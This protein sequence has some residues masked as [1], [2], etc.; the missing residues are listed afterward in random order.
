[1]SESITT[2]L[3]RAIRLIALEEPRA[4]KEL[5][6]RLEGMFVSFEFEDAIC[7]EAREGELYWSSNP[8]HSDIQVRGNRHAVLELIDGKATL[9]QT[10]ISGRLDIMGSIGELCRALSAVDYFI[11]ALLRID[12]AAELVRALEA[13]P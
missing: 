5:A 10:V 8:R 4:Y 7:L 12:A 6:Y 3:S 2:I 9:S 13:E 11:A 1:M